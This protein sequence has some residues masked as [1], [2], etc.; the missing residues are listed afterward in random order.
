MLSIKKIII[1]T[2]IIVISYLLFY[3]YGM[4]LTFW[5]GF[6]YLIIFSLIIFILKKFNFQKFYNFLNQFKTYNNLF[7]IFI[8]LDLINNYYMYNYSKYYAKITLFLFII[9]LL[10]FF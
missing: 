1:A 2:L 8:Y 3:P 10:L 4:F 6:N 5:W 7:L 9:S